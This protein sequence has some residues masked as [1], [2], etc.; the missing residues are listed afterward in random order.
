MW[1]GGQKRS[2]KHLSYFP[3]LMESG[4]GG[5]VARL[6]RSDHPRYN[7]RHLPANAENPM[8]EKRDSTPIKQAV[9]QSIWQT[10]QQPIAIIGLIVVVGVIIGALY[11]A[12]ATVTATTG[13]ELLQLQRTREF[14]TRSISDMQAQIAER[15]NISTL[16]GRAQQLGFEPASAADLNY[17]VVPGYS[18]IRA[19]ATPFAT[20]PPPLEYDET[21]EGFIRQQWDAL[22]KQFE[23]W[24]NGAPAE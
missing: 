24:M 2:G 11:L 15:R 10:P 21:F 13:T 17:L 14:L 16:R 4:C 20:Q 1:E 5:E 9:P 3:A 6:P 7:G 23:Q 12:Q 18:P 22:V 19:T 8:S